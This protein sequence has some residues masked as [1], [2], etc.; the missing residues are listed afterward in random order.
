MFT[1]IIEELGVVKSLTSKGAIST[2]QISAPGIARDTHPAQSVCLNGVCLTVVKVEKDTLSFEIMQQTLKDT[3][4]GLLKFADKVNLERALRVNGR[5]DG[6]FVSGHIDGTGNIRKSQKEGGDLVLEITT[7]SEQI[8]PYV[9]LKGSVALDGVSLTVS[10][11]E[12]NTFCVNLIPYTLKNST[13]G[14]KKEQDLVNIECDI[15]AKYVD[16]VSSLNK[17]SSTSKITS[18]FLQKHSFI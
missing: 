16:K 11:Q 15:L 18:S 7:A 8:L 14:L 6:H 3:S 17:Q 10:A 1:G 4:L 13:L 9:T 2:L 5:L 12:A